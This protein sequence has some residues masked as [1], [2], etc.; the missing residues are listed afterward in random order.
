[1]DT[2]GNVWRDGADRE[3]SVDVVTNEMGCLTEPGWKVLE[4]CGREPGL[5]SSGKV[6]WCAWTST[7]DKEAENPA[8]L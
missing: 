7:N 1:M 4:L 2:L 6:G 8:T 5:V 3:I